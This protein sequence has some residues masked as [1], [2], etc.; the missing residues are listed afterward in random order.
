[1]NEFEVSVIIPTLNRKKELLRALESLARQETTRRWEV[2]VVD[3]GSED[4]TEQQVTELAGAFSVPLRCTVE[5]A[6]GLSF[7][8]NR[9]LTEARS[10]T[11]LFVDDDVTCS[12]G[13]LEAHARAFE[14][15]RI[16]GTGGRVLPIFPEN[17]PEELRNILRSETGGPS[18][19]YDFGDEEMEVQAG[20]VPPLPFGCNM[21]V[22][23]SLALEIGGFRT[24]LGWGV[25]LI[26]G[27]DTEFFHRLVSKGYR[28]LYVPEASLFHHLDP[29]RATLAYYCRYQ[30]AVGRSTVVLS[31]HRGRLRHMG[32]I[33]KQLGRIVKYSIRALVQRSKRTKM[34]GKRA[35]SIGKLKQLMG[36]SFTKRAA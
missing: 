34:L 1:L 24:D 33:L 3:N 23:R 14:D 25:R 32:L 6:R 20:S 17:T 12:A 19:R 7:A 15:P 5:N 8:R 28:I 31:R 30:E 16:A 4:G 2:L 26:A 9:G 35:R 22:R 29:S 21:G 36:R 18:A 27:E 13:W 11:V 10:D